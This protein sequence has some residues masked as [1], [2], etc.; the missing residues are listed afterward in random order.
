[1]DASEAHLLVT[2]FTV[3]SSSWTEDRP[4]AGSARDTTLSRDDS[5][6]TAAIPLLD[7]RQNLH[8]LRQV[9]GEGGPEDVQ[10]DVE[11]VVDEPVAHPG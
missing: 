6:G 1:M 4:E 7:R 10:V 11:V 5:A 8:T 2:R 9:L 3:W